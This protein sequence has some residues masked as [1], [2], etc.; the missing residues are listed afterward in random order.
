M[1]CHNSGTLKGCMLL[2][3]YVRDH[4]GQ[5]LKLCFAFILKALEDIVLG[6]AA[7]GYAHARNCVMCYLLSVNWFHVSVSN[8]TTGPDCISQTK[9]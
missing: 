7:S 2:R 5:N 3:G 8:E 6:R 9:C 4:T 1:I